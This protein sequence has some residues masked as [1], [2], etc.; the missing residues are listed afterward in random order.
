MQEKSENTIFSKYKIFFY[1]LCIGIF[2]FVA[3]YFTEIKKDVKLFKKINPYWLSLALLG[4]ATTYFFGALVYRQ[5]I[6]VFNV[7]IGRALWKLSQVSIVTLFFNQTVPSAGLS[8]NTYFF[9]FL[10]KK[11]VAVDQAVSLI[12]IELLTFYAAMES[13]VLILLI[14]ISFLIRI[15]TLNIII[16]S[17]GFLVYLIFVL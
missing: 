14:A 7:K 8:G 11:D 2:V 12:S 3:V 10:R 9:S 16:L 17:A 15:P 5:L 4:Q 6:N 13:I 1:I